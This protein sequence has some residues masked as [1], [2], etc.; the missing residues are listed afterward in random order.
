MQ[1]G[2]AAHVDVGDHMQSHEW[3]C[4]S[5]S[6]GSTR[7]TPARVDPA[8]RPNQEKTRNEPH[9]SHLHLLYAD[10]RCALTPI[11]PQPQSRA[12]PPTKQ[13]PRQKRTVPS[14]T[15]RR[16]A[17]LARGPAR[18]SKASKQQQVIIRKLCL[19]NEAEI[20]S[21][22]SLEAYAEL[23]SKPL[24]EGQVAA[25]LSLFGWDPSILPAAEVAEVE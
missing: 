4:V 17:R 8:P 23:L 24:T 20:I 5:L 15:P 21:N 6:P 19:A 22:E 25:I 16:S 18:E 10:I 7:G 12:P 9:T 13:R 14:I 2:A 3:V 11:L 1:K